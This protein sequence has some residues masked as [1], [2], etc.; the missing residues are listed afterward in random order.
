MAVSASRPQFL[1]QEA[2]LVILSSLCVNSNPPSQSVDYYSESTFVV[3]VFSCST[4]FRGS[5]LLIV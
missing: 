1:F 2:L 5:L 3:I 4:T